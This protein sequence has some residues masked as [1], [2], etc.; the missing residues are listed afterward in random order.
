MTPAEKI[1]EKKTAKRRP[2]TNARRKLWKCRLRAVRNKLGLSIRDV[3]QGCGVS[4][5]T[6]SQAE[7]G[8]DI[9][10][11]TA[12]KLAAFFGMRIDELWSSR[13]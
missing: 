11:S 5:V 2:E 7:Q 4:N 3:E 8:Y 9:R 1:A 12:T 13:P 10:L 6:V